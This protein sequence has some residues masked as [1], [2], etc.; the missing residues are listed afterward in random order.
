[1]L[2]RESIILAVQVIV[3]GV[4]SNNR[5]TLVILRVASGWRHERRT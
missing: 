1:M 5:L 2:R 3:S 4:V